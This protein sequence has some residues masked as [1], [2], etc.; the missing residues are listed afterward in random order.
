MKQSWIYLILVCLLELCWVFGFNVASSWWH[1]GLILLVLWLDLE[2]LRKACEALPTGTVYAIFAAA[3]TAGTAVMDV[4]LFGGSLKM[5]KLFFI[6][7]LIGGVVGL[8]LADR[9]DKKRAE[10]GSY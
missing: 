1:W 10:G 2:C 7:L 5:A 6:T 8:K 3:G 9:K 4:Y